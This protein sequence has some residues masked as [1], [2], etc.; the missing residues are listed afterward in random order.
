MAK[1]DKE[2]LERL[3]SSTIEN[4]CIS[5]LDEF[6]K[7]NA[8]LS[9]EVG[10]KAY[11]IREEVFKCCDWCHAVSGK[12]VYGTEPKDIYRRHDNCKCMVL[13]K[14]GKEPY[15][16]V[17]SKKNYDKYSEARNERI[18]RIINYEREYSRKNKIIETTILSF[19]PYKKEYGDKFK[20]LGESEK[21]TKEIY[22]RVKEIL[23]HRS[24]T[25]YEDLILID[26]M[27][28]ISRVNKDC[29]ILKAVKINKT[30]KELLKN[31]SEYSVIG[32]HNHPDGTVPSYADLKVAVDRKYKYG[33]AV[34]HNG[35]IF[36]Y[37]VKK[38]A[39]L[40]E[41]D[42]FL[43]L[44]QKEIYNQNEKGIKK[45]IEDLKTVGVDLEII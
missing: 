41:A 8:E 21:A 35:S 38:T 44:L 37:S 36:K 28:G 13:F 24:G 27:N 3:L 33:I 39:N 30:Q 15:Q 18:N 45:A 40:E 11:I 29:E 31:T 1:D 9:A 6:N 7:A 32:I 22:K 14:R 19:D 16:D 5:F 25:E 12:Y 4:I 34:C 42:F 43:E 10:L 26:S 20:Q 23:L 17:W 2:V